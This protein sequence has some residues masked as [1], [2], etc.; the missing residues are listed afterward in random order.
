MKENVHKTS[1]QDYD[2][3]PEKKIKFID[4]LLF[5]QLALKKLSETVGLYTT[6]VKKA[7]DYANYEGMMPPSMEV[8]E[9]WY[10]QK[11]NSDYVFKFKNE[12]FEYLKMMRLFY[13]Y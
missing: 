7:D 6:V 11:M 12:I 9:A 3:F 1:G 8:S 5:M 10:I 4:S 2:H 13:V